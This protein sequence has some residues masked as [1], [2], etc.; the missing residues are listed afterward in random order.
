MCKNSLCGVQDLQPL[1]ERMLGTS[2]DHDLMEA[3]KI[4]MLRLAF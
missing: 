2:E 1:L 4:K 3:R